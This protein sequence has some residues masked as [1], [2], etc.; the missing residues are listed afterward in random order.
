VDQSIKEDIVIG[1]VSM[2]VVVGIIV[3]HTK[4]FGNTIIETSVTSLGVTNTE[5]EWEPESYVFDEVKS[6]CSNAPKLT[7]NSRG[8][9]QEKVVL[10]NPGLH[11]QDEL[12]NGKPIQPFIDVYARIAAL[13]REINKLNRSKGD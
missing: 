13:E 6:M 2:L 5:L 11:S 12:S 8:E 9:I 3:G 4:F 10:T 7:L 1:M